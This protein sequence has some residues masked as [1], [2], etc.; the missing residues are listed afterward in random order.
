MKITINY[1]MLYISFDKIKM[2]AERKIIITVLRNGQ[3]MK[4]DSV[5]LVPGDVFEPQ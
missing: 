4:I 1:I 5:D 2:M 3:K